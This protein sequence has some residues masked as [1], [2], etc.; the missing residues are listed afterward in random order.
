MTDEERRILDLVIISAATG[1]VSLGSGE[2][3]GA[4]RMV[5]V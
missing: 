2:P 5:D 3:V 1:V 4:V